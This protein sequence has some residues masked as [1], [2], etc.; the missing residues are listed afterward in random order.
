MNKVKK[1]FFLIASVFLI[2][3]LMYLILLKMMS[4]GPKL[5]SISRF[6]DN[7][8][9]IK[10][11]YDKCKRGEGQ[12]VGTYSI[13]TFDSPESKTRI[14]RKFVL[15]KDCSIKLFVY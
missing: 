11:A 8:V 14:K 13:L 3:S 12:K 7:L 4:F 15:D 9:L 10:K 5:Y 2:F 1:S 6:D